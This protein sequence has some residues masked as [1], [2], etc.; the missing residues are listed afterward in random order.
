MKT[1]FQKLLAAGGWL[2][3]RA[4]RMIVFQNISIYFFFDTGDWQLAA[5][6]I[7]L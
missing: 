5:G 2:T 1:V 4:S 6:G 3:A 7:V